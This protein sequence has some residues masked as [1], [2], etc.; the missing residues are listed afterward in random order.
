M[1]ILGVDGTQVA[2]AYAIFRRVCSPLRFSASRHNLR[3]RH[4]WLFGNVQHATDDLA[5][6]AFEGQL[7]A[8]EG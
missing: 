8:K 7:S 3:P 1:D 5:N 4:D 6:K 2:S